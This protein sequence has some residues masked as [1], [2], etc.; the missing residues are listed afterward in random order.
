[1]HNSSLNN[2]KVKET[3]EQCMQ[4]SGNLRLDIVTLKNALIS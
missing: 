1:M 4:Y 3:S 2:D